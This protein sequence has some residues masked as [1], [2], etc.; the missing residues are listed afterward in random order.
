MG[1]AIGLGLAMGGL[2]AATSLLGSARQ[3]SQQERQARAL[4]AQAGEYRRQ[5]NL[6]RQKGEI[7]AAN[8]DRRKS[9]LRREYERE[10]SRNRILL[11]SGNVD[12]GSG[13]ARDAALG[14]IDRFAADIGE[15]AYD[16]AL[17]QWEANENA[18]T[19]DY[20]ARDADAR[21]NYLRRTASNMGPGLLT[22]A[23]SGAG[24]F[25]SGYTMA[26]GKF[27]S[28]TAKDSWSTLWDKKTGEGL[29]MRHP[30]GKMAFYPTR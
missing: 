30:S 5:E 24:G 15:N 1:S 10:Q 2:S 21:A 29:Y 9:Q 16:R 28:A 26:G 25:V 11:G 19:L 23:L 4:E 14:N 18:K 12:M 3:R 27:G 13:S 20:Q 7:E 6:A 22:A 8:V 17:K